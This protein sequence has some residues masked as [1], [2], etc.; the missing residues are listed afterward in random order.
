VGQQHQQ[1][2]QRREIARAP[3][4]AL[5]AHLVRIRC[6]LCRSCS[7]SASRGRTGSSGRERPEDAPGPAVLGCPPHTL[8]RTVREAMVPV[9]SPILWPPGRRGHLDPAAAPVF[10]AHN[11]PAHACTFVR[12]YTPSTAC[13]V[14][15]TLRTYGKTPRSA[16]T[17]LQPA[18]CVGIGYRDRR[19]DG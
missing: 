19:E 4:S 8:W 18:C 5:A 1:H 10:S 3:L 16:A 11:R 17:P 7:V 13:P 6:G 15:C 12:R 2:E 14:R 9:P